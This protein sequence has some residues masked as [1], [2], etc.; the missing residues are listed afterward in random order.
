MNTT[1]DAGADRRRSYRRVGG[2]VEFQ[3]EYHITKERVL[4][5]DSM[6]KST[7]GL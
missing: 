1:D 3:L 6:P 4:W 5:L 2:V 7:G